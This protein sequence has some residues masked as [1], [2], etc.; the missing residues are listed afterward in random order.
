MLAMAF[1]IVAAL[2]LVTHRAT[3]YNLLNFYIAHPLTAAIGGALLM[4]NPPLLDILPMYVIFLACSPLVLSWS[5]K[6]GWRLPLAASFLFWLGAQLGMR[7]WSH[8]G[9][10]WVTH[11]N[12]P[13]QE[14][15]AFSW[16]AWQAVWMAGLW[17]GARSA[18]DKLPLRRI[19]RPL[20]V[21]AL[22]VCLFFI[23][24][25]YQLLGPHLTQ[26][27]LAYLIDKWH[28]GALRVLNLLAF[29][30]L[31]YRLRR[32][33]FIVVQRE[34]FIKLGKASLEVSARTLCSC[35]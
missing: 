11:L 27:T 26:Q 19:G 16:L 12:I 1:T 35:F 9:V 2:A 22:V 10:V 32:Y 18:E 25:R 31:F 33:L 15:G 4:Y 24:V 30:V 7:E 13:L 20:A 28:I 29:T 8:A 34:P 5:A 23:G 6:H 21:T 14:T 3:I 17:V